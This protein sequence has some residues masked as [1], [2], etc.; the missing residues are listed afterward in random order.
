VTVLVLTMPYIAAVS[1][2]IWANF[3]FS[4]NK[5]IADKVK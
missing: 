1:K 5:E 2:S 3:F 4:Y